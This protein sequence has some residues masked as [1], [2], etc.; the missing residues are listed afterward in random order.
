MPARPARW[1][2]KHAAINGAVA[3]ALMVLIN[4]YF[5]GQLMA[6]GIASIAMMIAGGALGGAIL[7]LLVALVGNF[8][9]R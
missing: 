6:A 8:I 2:V 5:Q 3:G 1:S 7:F 9:T 4:L